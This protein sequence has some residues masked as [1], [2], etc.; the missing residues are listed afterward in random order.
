ML[1]LK[2]VRLNW[3]KVIVPDVDENGKET[4]SCT[5]IVPKSDEVQLSA[6]KTEFLKAKKIAIEKFGEKATK[7][8]FDILKD[9]DSDDA[10]LSKYNTPNLESF[11]F[12][13]KNNSQPLIIGPKC[14]PLDDASKLYSGMYANV[15]VNAGSWT[16]KGKIGVSYYL[17]AI[18]YINDKGENL[19]GSKPSADGFEHLEDEAL[20]EDEVFETLPTKKK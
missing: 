9:G 12:T 17:E 1:V 4:Y 8:A 13:A 10:K 3:L 14:T 16:F 2:N 5:V 7:I 15:K 19:G 6:L 18:Q 20:G 11:F